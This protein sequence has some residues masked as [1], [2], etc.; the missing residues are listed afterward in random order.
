MFFFSA[1]HYASTYVVPS[2]DHPRLEYASSTLPVGLNSHCHDNR[3]GTQHSVYKAVYKDP[4]CDSDLRSTKKGQVCADQ[5]VYN[6]MEELSVRGPP[7]GS[8]QEHDNGTTQPGSHLTV[9]VRHQTY[10]HAK[11]LESVGYRDPD[12]DSE[13]RSKLKCPIRAERPVYNHVEELSVRGATEPAK[14]RYNGSKQPVCTAFY[15]DPDF[16]SELR[17]KLKGPVRAEQHVY[18]HVEELSMQG[19]TGPAKGR[20]SGTQQS[21]CKAVYKDPDLDSK[22]RPKKKGRVCV[23]QPVYN[24]VEDFSVRGTKRPAK[25]PTKS[26]DNGNQQPVFT[27]LYKDPN[28]DKELRPKK[29]GPVCVQQPVYNHVEE[30]PVRETKGPV[31]GPDNSNQQP[32]YTAVYKDPD[33]DKE[34]RPKKKGPVCVQQ[35]VYNHVEDLLVREAKG[36]AKGPDNGNQ[37]PVFTAVYKDPDLDKELRPKKKGP[38]CVQQPV[39]N[40]VE[41]LLVRETKGPV[42][43]PDNGNQQPLYTAVYKDPDLDKELRPKKKGPVCVQQPVYNH[44]EELSVPGTKG[45]ANGRENDTQPEYN[46]LESYLECSRRPSQYGT[47][48]SSAELVS[49]TMKKSKPDDTKQPNDS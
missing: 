20:D 13:L 16:D 34:L 27:A 29:K 23:Q 43:G 49:N 38:V 44:I 14:D 30:L 10:A 8:V 32:L 21:V 35:P 15:K 41:D 19:A 42:K 18:N 24:H 22:L 2:R 33:L 39:Y 12:F 17:S 5:P 25:G 6:Q 11:T 36:P 37:Q 45:P 1:I 28:L 9:P 3:A 31:K 46:V 4:N 40:H 48:M 47:M 26:P 7:L